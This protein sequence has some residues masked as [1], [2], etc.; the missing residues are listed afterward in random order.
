MMS[1]LQA[2]LY[3]K[4]TWFERKFRPQDDDAIFCCLVF[5]CDMYI[6]GTYEQSIISVQFQ[7]ESTAQNDTYII[8]E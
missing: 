8:L 6:C 4:F 2:T 7:A 1:K 3:C 5:I